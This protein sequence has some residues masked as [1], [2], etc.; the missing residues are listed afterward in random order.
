MTIRHLPEHLGDRLRVGDIGRDGI[1]P[2]L[3]RGLLGGLQLEVVDDDLGPLLREPPRDA[4]ADA[5]G[6][7]RHQS[8]LPLQSSHGIPS[9]SPRGGSKTTAGNLRLRHLAVGLR[10]EASPHFSP[11][12]WNPTSI[13]WNPR[14]QRGVLVLNRWMLAAAL[15]GALGVILGAFGA[16]G[17]QTRLSAEQLESWDTAVRY[18]LLHSVA[19]LA[20]ALFAIESGR[21]IQLAR[22]ALQ[23]GDS[24]LLGVD[25]PP[26]ADRAAL[27]GPG[28]AAGWPLPDRRLALA[29]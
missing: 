27:A 22:L 5:A 4:G 19:L 14:H 29:A 12:Q 11:R 23:S 18:H 6:G 2:E 3:A 7:A 13:C 16:H 8:E 28:D 17:L 26:G 24:V 20:L 10:R 9:P 21:S 1:P 25:L 15:L